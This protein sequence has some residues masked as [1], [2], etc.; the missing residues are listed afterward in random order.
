MFT[1][2]SM[3]WQEPLNMLPNLT[4]STCVYPRISSWEMQVLLINVRKIDIH[5][6]DPY[7]HK[8]DK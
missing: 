5:S 2:L 4:I 8:K 6:I 3:E 1:G 7:S